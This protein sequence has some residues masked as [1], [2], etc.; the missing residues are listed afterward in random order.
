MIGR[1]CNTTS[2]A[3]LA[4]LQQIVEGMDTSDLEAFTGFEVDVGTLDSELPHTGSTNATPFHKYGENLLA[5]L[6]CLSA[7]GQEQPIVV[8][9][10][11]VPLYEAEC[12][13]VVESFGSERVVLKTTQSAEASTDIIADAAAPPIASDHVDISDTHEPASLFVNGKLWSW[14]THS[15]VPGWM[16]VG[17]TGTI[18]DCAP[19][20]ERQAP[21]PVAGSTTNIIDLDG[22]CVLPGLGDAHMHVGL[23]GETFHQVNLFGSTSIAEL[24]ERLAAFAKARPDLDFITG[25]GWDVSG[26]VGSGILI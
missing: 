7:I 24:C 26:G 25:V 2:G 8:I 10:P 13:R 18:E 15:F 6:R 22:K 23:L 5:I 20:A 9:V 14:A 16:A 4:T 11:K 21:M 3:A 1:L 12:R 19:N 17:S